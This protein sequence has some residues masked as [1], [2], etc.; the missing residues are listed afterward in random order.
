M[1][2]MVL[3]IDCGTTSVRSLAFEVDSGRHGVCASEN[4]PLLF[5][6]PGWVEVD[7]D[8]LADAAI[9]V[10][11]VGLDRIGQ[12]GDTAV[13]LGLTHM[14]ETAIAWQRST[15][16]PMY[17][18]IMWMSQQSDPIVAEWRAELLLVRLQG[19][20]AARR[21]PGG[22]QARRGGRSCHRDH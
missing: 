14:R 10:T 17:P 4:V 1:T 9:G 13:A 21:S 18:G 7:P 3:A 19:R 15:K 20:L 8:V 22:A 12:H 6:A 5:P 11:K 2:R 16:Q